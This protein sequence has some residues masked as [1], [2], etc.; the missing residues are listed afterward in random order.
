MFADDCLCCELVEAAASGS[1]REGV[2]LVE[3]AASGSGRE[4]V[5]FCGVAQCMDCAERKGET[6]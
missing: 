4:G 1:G 6:V 3:A 5:L 2:L